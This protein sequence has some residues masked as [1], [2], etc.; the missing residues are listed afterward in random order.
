MDAVSER[1]TAEQ[2]I[3][4]L[5]KLSLPEL[6]QVFEHALAVQAER[7]APRLGSE[8][9]ALLARVNEGLPHDLR[10]RLVALRKKREDASISD[11]EYAELTELTD[12]AEILHAERMAA[13]ADLAKL[14]GVSLSSLMDNLGIHFPQNA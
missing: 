11:A 7:R 4:A 12:K 13:L 1:M 10:L 5:D 9:S 2:I 14:R 6:E 8:E 3:A